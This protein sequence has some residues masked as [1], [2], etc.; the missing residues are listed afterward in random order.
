MPTRVDLTVLFP[1]YGPKAMAREVDGMCSCRSPL[2]NPTLAGWRDALRLHTPFLPR[3][4][5]SLELGE[6]PEDL[7]RTPVVDAIL[8]N[9][10]FGPPS[11]PRSLSAAGPPV[12]R[13]ALQGSV[14]PRGVAFLEGGAVLALPLVPRNPK[15]ATLPLLGYVL[16]SE[17]AARFA[18]YSAWA[19]ALKTLLPPE[20]ATPSEDA[21]LELLRFFSRALSRRH[22]PR[23]PAHLADLVAVRYSVAD[24]IRTLPALFVWD[25]DENVV[26]YEDDVD[27][28]ADGLPPVLMPQLERALLGR[29]VALPP[30]LPTPARPPKGRRK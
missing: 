19:V 17:A 8:V 20:T 21:L 18:L 1:G 5:Y 14:S 16:T 4:Q 22:A 26:L 15:D 28:A 29:A 13:S 6:F 2:G 23:P 30:A 3:L 7:G 27:S 11:F 9:A 12:V 10:Q 25:A 24:A